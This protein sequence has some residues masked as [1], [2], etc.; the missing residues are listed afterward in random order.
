MNSVLLCCLRSYNIKWR[1]CCSSVLVVMGG[2][3]FGE[4][5]IDSLYWKHAV[6]YCKSRGIFCLPSDSQTICY[7]HCPGCQLLFSF[8]LLLSEA[9]YVKVLFFTFTF[10]YS[11]LLFFSF[12]NWREEPK[13][14]ICFKGLLQKCIAANADTFSSHFY[15]WM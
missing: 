2:S 4:E 12:W 6:R 14:S 11:L 3:W 1:K 7:S 9:R 8:P 10:Y 15:V 5:M 13:A